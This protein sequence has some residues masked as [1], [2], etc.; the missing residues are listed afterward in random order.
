[1]CLSTTR[2]RIGVTDI[3]LK[4]LKELGGLTFGTGVTI[5]CNHDLGGVPVINDVLMMCATTPAIS[6]E[7]S[8]KIQ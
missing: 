2:E 8:L 4:S 5:A 1:M 6:Y 3:G 7:N